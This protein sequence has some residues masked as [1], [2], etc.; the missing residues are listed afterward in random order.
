M[1]AVEQVRSTDIYQVNSTVNHIFNQ[2]NNE[3]KL[4]SPDSPP[5]RQ[6]RFFRVRRQQRSGE[7]QANID[8]IICKNFSYL[9]TILSFRT[10]R[11]RSSFIGCQDTD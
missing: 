5:P 4:L 10:L 9:I 1:M 6:S 8:G 11:N 7:N 3:I 2:N